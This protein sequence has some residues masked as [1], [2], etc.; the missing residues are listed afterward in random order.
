MKTVMSLAL[1]LVLSLADRPSRGVTPPQ[2]D[3]P[4][5]GPSSG[6]LDLKA[7]HRGTEEIDR[8]LLDLSQPPDS[9]RAFFGAVRQAFGAH[10]MAS[11]AELPAIRE[12][13]ERHAI[14]V[15]GG[16]MLGALTHDGVRIWVRTVKP[17]QVEA[18]VRIAGTERRFGPVSSTVESDFTAVVP[19]TGLEPNTRH[20]YRVAVD[21]QSIPMP[22][23][24]VIATTPTPGDQAR[25]TI[26]FGADFHK[27]GLWNRALLDRMRK[28]GSSAFLLLGDGAADDRDNQ[29]GLHRSDYLLRDLSPGWR[30][31]VAS[32]A[33]HATWDDHDYFNND[34]SGIP[35]PFSAADRAAVRRVWTESWNNPSYGFEDRGEGIFF[36]TR[37]GP[38]DV[39]MLD[40]RFFR[41]ERGEADSFLGAAQM[42]WLEDQLAACA[43]P[44]VIITSGTMWSDS[45]TAGKDSWGVWDPES[46]ER[47]LALIEERRI[48]GVL[49]LSGD[50]H[51]ARVMR[52]PRPSGYSF[53][54]F[55]LG[56]LGAHPGPP[57]MGDAPDQQ[58]FALTGEAVFGVCTFDTT[59][60]DPTAT[61][62][63]VDAEG[64][65]RYQVILTRSQLTPPAQQAAP[66]AE[67]NT[68][69][70]SPAR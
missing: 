10:P 34:K 44:F 8:A 42:R 1:M 35:T 23:G 21:G 12:A 36:R 51:G 65:E 2:A 60:A 67:N 53:W 54:E 20:P 40:T 26:A 39:I 13:A 68:Q 64:K 24:A 69:T 63:I 55:E 47:I 18:W 48:G 7:A 32:T 14:P 46:R 59:L 62:R 41:T 56:S 31:L 6:T 22:D 27:T 17:A 4:A 3:R 29:V 61:I 15:L 16:P 30:E 9:I 11:F 28:S 33:V 43:G 57:A 58:P 52:L 19:V 38:C 70:G 50:R 45:I 5:G 25:T 66:N 37:L 49:L